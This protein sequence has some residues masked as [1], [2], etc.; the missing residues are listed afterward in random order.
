MDKFFKQFY[1]KNDYHYLLEFYFLV[2]KML[3]H[4]I[5]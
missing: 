1:Y 5:K 3:L 4:F 2:L